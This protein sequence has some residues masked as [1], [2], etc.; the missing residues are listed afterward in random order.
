M[1]LGTTF[2]TDTI[3]RAVLAK[4]P[5][6]RITPQRIGYLINQREDVRCIGHTTWEKIQHDPVRAAE[7]SEIRSIQRSGPSQLQGLQHIP[8]QNNTDAIYNEPGPLCQV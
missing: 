3:F 1:D 7:V 2:K 4:Y 5:K 8:P 6:W